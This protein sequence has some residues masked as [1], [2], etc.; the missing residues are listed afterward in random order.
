MMTDVHSENR[1]KF[2]ERFVAEAKIML[3][4]KHERVG[5]YLYIL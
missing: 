3:M 4:M 5:K 1:I 2:I